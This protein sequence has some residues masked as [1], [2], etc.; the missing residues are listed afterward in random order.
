MVHVVV[1]PCGLAGGGVPLNALLPP[2]KKNK[3]TSF[4]I[5]L[6]RDF[7]LTVAESCTPVA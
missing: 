3:K 4:S 7:D 1:T 6:H 5:K 2:E